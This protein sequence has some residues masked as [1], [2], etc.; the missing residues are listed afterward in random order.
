VYYQQVLQVQWH[1]KYSFGD[2]LFNQ[3]NERGNMWNNQLSSDWE[4]HQ[5]ASLVA[6]G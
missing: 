1:V 5:L 6:N 3:F 4:R 2:Y